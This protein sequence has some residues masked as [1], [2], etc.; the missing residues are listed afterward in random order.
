MIQWLECCSEVTPHMSGNLCNSR[1]WAR[2]RLQFD[3]NL[4]DRIR[5][6]SG[7]KNLELKANFFETKQS[8]QRKTNI[9]SV[10]FITN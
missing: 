10:S 7:V 6:H 1:N 8:C 9:F 3:G 4:F 5:V 2:V